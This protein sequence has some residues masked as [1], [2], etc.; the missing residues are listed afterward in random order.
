MDMDNSD[1][2]D[3]SA[4][5][6]NKR[7]AEPEVVTLDDDGDLP[8]TKRIKLMA[9]ESRCY[10]GC[11]KTCNPPIINLVKHYNFEETLFLFFIFYFYYWFITNN[12]TNHIQ[13]LYTNYINYVNTSISLGISNI[14]N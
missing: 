10:T 4:R 3:D 6:P 12:S 9:A 2:E 5:K 13:K 1:N 7:R 11:S 8:E 14:F